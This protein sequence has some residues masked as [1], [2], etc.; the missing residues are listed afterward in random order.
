MVWVQ[1]SFLPNLEKQTGLFLRVTHYS[2]SSYTEGD[3]ICCPSM[4]GLSLW[5]FKVERTKQR[6]CLSY[7]TATPLPYS[8]LSQRSFLWTL[9]APSLSRE[10]LVRSVQNSLQIHLKAPVSVVLLDS[11]LSC[12]ITVGPFSNSVNILATSYLPDWRP[13][14]PPA[15]SGLQC[16]FEVLS[17]LSTQAG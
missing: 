8:C 6:I 12:Q 1:S 2:V 15:V 4:W 10:N 7:S 5:F 14:L 17:S 13:C 9:P 16:S 3:R 11:V